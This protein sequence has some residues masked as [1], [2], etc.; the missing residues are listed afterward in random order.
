[1]SAEEITV[2][3]YLKRLFLLLNKKKLQAVCERYDIPIDY[4]RLSSGNAKVILFAPI[5]D[6]MILHFSGSCSKT[7]ADSKVLKQMF[8][9]FTH[10]SKCGW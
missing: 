8:C 10:I 1:M 9:K 6:V 5:R 3:K 4:I 7:V 2:M